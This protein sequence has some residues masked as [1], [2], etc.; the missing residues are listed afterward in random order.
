MV[1]SGIFL[2]KIALTPLTAWFSTI[3]L[4][5]F[6]PEKVTEILHIH[7]VTILFFAI[8]CWIR[9]CNLPSLQVHSQLSSSNFI[10]LLECT[11][12]VV[13]CSAFN[14][15]NN[16]NKAPHTIEKCKETGLDEEKSASQA[17]MWWSI[18][19]LTATAAAAA[20]SSKHTCEFVCMAERGQG[21]A[22]R[23]PVEKR[24]PTCLGKRSKCARWPPPPL[25]VKVVQIDR[26]AAQP[27][28]RNWG[29]RRHVRNSLGGGCSLS[30][31][32]SVFSV[33]SVGGNHAGGALCGVGEYLGLSEV[34]P[35]AK[36]EHYMYKRA[37]N[38]NFRRLF[39]SF[40]AV[41]GWL[42]WCALRDTAQCKQHVSDWLM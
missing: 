9:P 25:R 38:G 41:V 29:Q 3:P 31:W 2:I 24:I 10:H 4:T 11:C 14:D 16:N 1:Y 22:S 42:V 36:L 23:W 32:L 26:P 19:D 18:R 30:V 35:A 5:G 39:I 6:S 40:V 27:T 12:G 34:D 20:T 21:N 8:L 7:W 15:N 13:W 37:L 17:I 33:G 28:I